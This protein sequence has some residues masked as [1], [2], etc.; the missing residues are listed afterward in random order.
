MAL[1]NVRLTKADEEAV[2]IL[3]RSRVEISTV[4]RN[5]LHREAEK[6]RPRS[7]AFTAGVLHEIFERYPEPDRAAPR[8]YDVHDRRALADAIR[9]HLRAAPAGGRRRRA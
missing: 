4:V 8:G 3:K 9:D 2:R 1:L 6:L 7:A 5:A